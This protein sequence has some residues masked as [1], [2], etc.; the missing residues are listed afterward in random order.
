MVK[1]SKKKEKPG[2]VKMQ[3]EVQ[4]VKTIDEVLER[5]DRAKSK[6]KDEKMY[7]E[8]YNLEEPGVPLKFSYG[9]TKKVEKFHLMHG[10]KYNLTREVLHH[11]ESRQLP[12][13]DFQPDG[14]GRMVKV[15]TGYKSRFQCRQ[16]WE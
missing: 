9:S 2:E 15:R 1:V 10:G 14:T 12:M 6:P 3:T 16:V 5:D 4:A 8:F 7:V 13:Y 11:L